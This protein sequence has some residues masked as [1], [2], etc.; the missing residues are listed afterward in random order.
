MEGG[1]KLLYRGKADSSIRSRLSTPDLVQPREVEFEGYRSRARGVDATCYG[2]EV[3]LGGSKAFSVIV[4]AGTLKCFSSP[5]C[6]KSREHGIPIILC[7]TCGWAD[8]THC[9]SMSRDS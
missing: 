6:P 3:L 2:R 8:A 4:S 9:E 5:A 1:K 7:V